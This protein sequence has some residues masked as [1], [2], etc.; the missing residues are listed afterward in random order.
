MARS[1][2]HQPPKTD[3]C[4]GQIGLAYRHV[5]STH[6]GNASNSSEVVLDL[7][8]ISPNMAVIQWDLAK[9]VK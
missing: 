1:M 9:F 2:G 5:V 3:C 8:V 6:G 4:G 7:T